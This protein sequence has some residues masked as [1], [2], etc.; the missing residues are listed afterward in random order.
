MASSQPAKRFDWNNLRVR[1][2]SAAIL[3]P[4]AL[5]A[6][7]F[8]GP[9]YLVVI[10][11]AVAL[12]TIEWGAMCDPAN[13]GR[14]AVVMSTA[15]LAAVFAAYL[16]HPLIGWALVTLGAVAGAVFTLLRRKI[17]RPADI[18]FGVLYV[19]APTVALIWLRGSP[20]GRAWV[21]LLVA[22]VWAADIAAFLVGNW[23]KGPKLW[24]R[25]SPNKT[26]TGFA[27]GLV[28]GMAAAAGMAALPIGGGPGVGAAI[29]IGLLTAL[30]A[31]GGDLWESALKR[32]FGVKDS[33]DLIPGHG[34]LLDR[35]DGL[36]FAAVVVAA[37]RLA[38]DYGL[39]R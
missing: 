38:A 37:V 6:L 8:G 3:A 17:D 34:G 2:L 28:G 7:W 4:I 1:V 19:G 35:V 26:W 30:A 16:G 23:L 39:W 36:M 14:A 27:G 20:G 24:P 33:G 15:I 10:A 18:A 25:F 22:V 32:R 5:A 11:V 31:M 29:P 13:A 21:L 12:L 9:L